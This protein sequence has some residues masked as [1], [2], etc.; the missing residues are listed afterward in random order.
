M[1]F[2]AA[3]AVLPV[4][5]FADMSRQALRPSDVPRVVLPRQEGISL[6]VGWRFY[7]G[8]ISAPPLRDLSS[9]YVAAKA[10]GSRGAAA[11]N[12]NDTDWRSVDLPHDWAIEAPP[13]PTENIAEGY[14]KRGFGWYRRAITIDPSMTGRYLEIQFGAIASN[15]TVWFNGTPVA[16]NWSGYNGFKIDITALA[17]FGDKPNI[18]AVRVDAE[19]AE[20]WW[21]E[22]AGI[23]RDVRLVSRPAVS[24]ITDGVHA[25]P[26]RQE[27]GRWRIPIEVSLY[28]IE[29]A[30]A[31]V[32]IVADLLDE[33]G[34]V[35][36][37]TTT[38]GQVQPL[39]TDVLSAEI[40]NI[41][42]KLWSVE[43][44]NLYSV[45]VRVLRGGVA[46]DERMTSCGFR[47][48][49]FDSQSGFYLNDKPLKIKGVCLHQDHA[50]LGVA[51][52]PAIVEWRIRQVK[53]MG[54]NAIRCSHG[55][56]D[57]SLLE[58][59]DRHGLMVMD[60]NRNFNISP[61]YIEQL[62]WLVRRDRNRPSV[63]LW[64]VFNE[65][66]LQG[67]TNGYE[68]VRRANA[69]VKALDDSRPVTAAMSAGLFTPVNVSQAVD[70]VGFNYQ[71]ASYDRFHAAHP[72]V[73]LLSSEDT[74]GFMT[75]GEW[76][77]D[78]TKEIE[79]SDDTRFAGWGLS[80]RDSWKAIE[81]RPFMAG[82][83]VWTG[84]DYHGE[85][86]P[87]KWPANS[88]YFGILDLCG[89]RKS[90]FYIRRALWQKD[91]PVADILP[92]WNWAGQ[93]G[94]PVN[95][96]LATNVDRVE[97][98]CN[99]RLVGT[100]APDPYEMIT[101]EVP[102]E[103]GVLE[104]KGWKGDKVVAS[105]KVETTGAPVCLRI[106]ADRPSLAGDGVDAQPLTI[107]VLDAKKR[108]VPTA[109]IDIDLTID[110]GRIIGVG[111]GDPTSIAP[112]KGNKVCLFNGLAQVIVQSV[113]GGAGRLTVSASG[114]G[115]QAASLAL[116]ISPAEI[117][118]SL[119]PSFEVRVTGWRQSPV[120]AERPSKIPDLADGDMN[121]WD[122]IIAGELPAAASASGYVILTA[123]AS[124]T[125]AMVTSGAILHFGGIA[126]AGDVQ[127]DAVVIGHK[128][129][130]DLGPLNVPIPAG[131]R[132]IVIAVVLQTSLGQ[133][134]GLPKAVSIQK[135]G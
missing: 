53:S 101:F 93:E 95:V 120:L 113:R 41:Q 76:Q 106:T 79:S 116:D 131:K 62:E 122:P 70:V 48:I 102:Y 18:L 68:M 134:V 28:S 46:V 43:A 129:K 59:C 89:F 12:F 87:F 1:G 8:D 54:A 121:S 90:A 135:A 132:D 26:R 126:G 27:D 64:S 98:R 51:V 94:K 77:T 110:G 104:A 92:H 36:G 34:A 25:D 86:T 10:G 60:E 57:V 118:E 63:V 117:P 31:Q 44:P 108:P 13:S 47:T 67:T 74:S 52:P 123:K 128:E 5:T 2:G 11:V 115:V 75:R 22:G 16:H 107:E 97:L 82:S 99:G 45:R 111:N 103:P 61:E 49:R 130:A 105:S 69:A 3:S 9:S 124:L 109:N 96:M 78:K 14:R 33:T 100:G 119:P 6:N 71:H 39:Q 127:V 81:S 24:I 19:T 112:S 84:F 50:G 35:V 91:I 55:A 29:T 37:S 15:A 21:Y 42:P 17:T 56:P 65:E 30:A 85:P 72:D 23:Y 125:D 58:A 133:A 88:S 38:S 32:H 73:P 4:P 83:F 66:P 20:G 80:Q 40:A 7:P 114:A